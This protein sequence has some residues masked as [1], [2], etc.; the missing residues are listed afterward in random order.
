[1]NNLQFLFAKNDREPE[2][3][4]ILDGS[5]KL[6]RRPNSHQWQC[7]FK[8]ESGSWHQASTGSDQVAE[9]TGQ[10]NQIPNQSKKSEIKV[11]M[12]ADCARSWSTIFGRT[13]HLF[14][15]GQSLRAIRRQR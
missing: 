1:M 6:F 12:L 2:S 10:A 11:A 5:I 8:L 7:R 3:I 4:N 9:A 14:D 13:S 15:V